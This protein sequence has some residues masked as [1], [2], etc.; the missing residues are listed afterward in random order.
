M[1]DDLKSEVEVIKRVQA[2]LNEGKPVKDGE[3]S[4]DDIWYLNKHH[5]LSSKPMVYIA[6][7][8]QDE[9]IESF[10]DKAKGN[11]WIP[12]IEK[13]SKENRKGE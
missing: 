9:Y 7:V 4:S 6:N 8:G 1:I 3:W 10:E 2:M 5:F 11:K 13:Y 12:K